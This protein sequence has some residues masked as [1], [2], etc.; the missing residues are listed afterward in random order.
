M[1]ERGRGR[2]VAF[3]IGADHDSRH[4]ESVPIVT[5][6][7]RVRPA[8]PRSQPG[9]FHQ[10][11]QWPGAVTKAVR[12]HVIGF[13]CWWR[14]WY[15]VV[16]SAVFVVEPDEQGVWP[17]RAVHNGVDDCAG[18]TPRRGECLAG[19][20][21]STPR[22][23]GRRCSPV[24]ACPPR[25][26]GRSVR[27]GG[28]GRSCAL[29]PAG[30]GSPCIGAHRGC[31]ARDQGAAAGLAMSVRGRR[32]ARLR[33]CAQRGESPREPCVEREVLSTPVT[34]AP[35]TS[36][37][38]PMSSMLVT[39]PSLR[40][41]SSC[42]W[43]KRQLWEGTSPA[44]SHPQPGTVTLI[45]PASSRRLCSPRWP[46]GAS[47]ET[48]AITAGTPADARRVLTSSRSARSPV[49]CHAEELVPC[50]MLGRRIV[51]LYPCTS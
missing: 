14:R 18:E 48:C 40:P 50:R 19:S 41:W 8:A 3:D 32:G 27:C 36:A 22:N 39:N 29:A 20:P 28:G 34:H 6:V 42:R 51:T 21:P 2:V 45:R 37:S 46:P 16:V 49:A 4:P 15:V 1:V 12:E 11:S 38:A 17:A 47:G 26:A 23:P 9:V 5:P 30:T 35:V 10:P 25:H 13:G 7:A 33:R 43:L 24:V 44:S 31:P